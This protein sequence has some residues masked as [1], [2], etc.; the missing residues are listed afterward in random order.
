MCG[1][2]CFPAFSSVLAQAELLWPAYLSLLQQTLLAPLKLCGS[3]Q[4]PSCVCLDTSQHLDGSLLV[5]SHWALKFLKNPLGMSSLSPL[6]QDSVPSDT[7]W[8]S[9]LWYSI[10]SD[11]TWLPLL[12]GSVHSDAAWPPLLWGSVSSDTTWPPLPQ[13]SIYALWHTLSF[14]YHPAFHSLFE[15]CID[16]LV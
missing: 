1:S 15:Y 16:T 2:Y 11:T 13:G 10:H 14:C 8:P 6:C 4:L 12:Q 7:F 3:L 9:L 5:I